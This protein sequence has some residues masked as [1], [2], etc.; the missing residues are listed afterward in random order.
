[1]DGETYVLVANGIVA[2]TGYTPATPFN[3]YVY[4]MGREAATSSTNTDILVFHGSTDA[5][6]IDVVEVYAGAGTVVDDLSYGEFSG[7]LEL[8]TANY[9]LDIRVA[10]GD[11]TVASF[12]APLAELGLQ[13]QALTVIAS[14]FLNPANNN[15]G[16]SFGIF[17][18]LR[19]GGSFVALG[20]TTGIEKNEIA[21]GFKAYPNP[22]RDAV[23]LSFDLRSSSN[24]GYN[25]YD[26]SGRAVSQIEMGY[27]PSG[28]H[29]INVDTS[30]LP[31]GL[32]IVKLTAGNTL[33]TAKIQVVD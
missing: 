9:Q 13:G 30:T 1:M 33:S 27:L 11:A 6:T 10:S 16:A 24:V 19:S 12:N 17:A 26:A 4:G 25:I 21:A 3:I 2:P 22:V 15:N 28:N 29:L 20:N 18:V 23:N 5:P 7:Y 8:P 32:Y 31:S 14:G